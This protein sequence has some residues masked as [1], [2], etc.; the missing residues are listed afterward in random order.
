MHFKLFT[1]NFTELN[2]IYKMAGVRAKV[3][4]GHPPT[5][6]T[7]PGHDWLKWDKH[8]CEPGESHFP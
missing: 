8:I 4:G 3:Q 6:N 5:V 7:E 1:R 2:D